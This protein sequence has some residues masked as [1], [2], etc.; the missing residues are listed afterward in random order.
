MEKLS[1]R[2]LIESYLDNK[3][4]YY[5]YENYKISLKNLEKKQKNYVLI[6]H[7]KLLLDG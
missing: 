3:M 4:L 1:G 2:K 6:L 5:Y 7:L